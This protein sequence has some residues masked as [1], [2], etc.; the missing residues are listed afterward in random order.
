VRRPRSADELAEFV[1]LLHI[2]DILGQDD[3]GTWI[4]KTFPENLYIRATRVYDW[5]PS[6]E[7]VDTHVQSHGPLGAAYPDPP[8]AYEGDSPAIFHLVPNGLHDPAMVDQGGWGGRFAAEKK[9]GV[10][11]MSC[12]EGEDAAYDP[13]LMYNEASE[14]IS[15]WKEALENDFEARM[16][17]SVTGSYDAANHHPIAILNG[18]ETRRVLALS[19]AAGSSVELTGAGSS[20]PDGD[21]LSYSWWFYAEPSSFEGPVPIRGDRAESATVELPSSA[22]GKSLHVVLELRDHGSPP[23]TAYRRVVIE[24][25]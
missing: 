17:W 15:R 25:R 23:L 1:S 6:D 18:D 13:Y 2:S 22:V 21:R 24:V 12:M 11:G 9:T 7:W 16:D 14:S 5:Q 8:W 3:A 20:D 10:R 4:A 19:A